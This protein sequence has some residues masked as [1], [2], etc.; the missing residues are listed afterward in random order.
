MTTAMLWASGSSCPSLED[1]CL[2]TRAQSG[3]W[4]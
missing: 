4:P 1:F 3:L 2:S